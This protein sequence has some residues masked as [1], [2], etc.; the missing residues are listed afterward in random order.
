MGG[1]AGQKRHQTAQSTVHS[2]NAAA[3]SGGKVRNINNFVGNVPE[4]FFVP[5]QFCPNVHDFGQK[6]WGKMGGFSEKPWNIRNL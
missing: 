2:G 6:N 4:I 1:D 5:E 3:A